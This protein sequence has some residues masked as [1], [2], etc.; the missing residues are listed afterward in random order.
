VYALACY[1]RE[2]LIVM[3]ADTLHLDGQPA[4]AGQAQRLSQSGYAIVCDLLAAGERQQATHLLAKEGFDR[5]SANSLL[6]AL[7]QPLARIS[8]VLI[9]YQDET[10]EPQLYVLIEGASGFWLLHHPMSDTVN[11]S[12]SPVSAADFHTRLSAMLGAA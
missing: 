9:D 3:I 6:D 4:P 2:Q 10:V 1:P 7:A 8:M 5:A 11:F 12:A